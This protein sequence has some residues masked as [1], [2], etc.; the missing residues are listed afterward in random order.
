[1]KRKPAGLLLTQLQDWLDPPT[2]RMPAV[3]QAVPPAPPQPER[4]DP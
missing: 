4:S 3:P 1:M 2:I